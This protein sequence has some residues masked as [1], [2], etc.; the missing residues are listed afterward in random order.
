MMGIG[1]LIFGILTMLAFIGLMSVLFGW[2]EIFDV[3]IMLVI[4]TMLFQRKRLG[5]CHLPLTSLS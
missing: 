4:I 1:D 2:F 3:S 5:C